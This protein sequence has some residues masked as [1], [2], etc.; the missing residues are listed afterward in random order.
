MAL[1]A[2]ALALSACQRVKDFAEVMRFYQC[3]IELPESMLVIND[4]LLKQEELPKDEI[5][6][7]IRYYG[8]DECNECALNH[9]VENYSLASLAERE[10]GAFRLMIIMAPADED[11]EIVIRQALD[12]SLPA[13]IYVD[14]SY[15][16]ESLGVIPGF[17]G[18]RTFLLNIK[19]TPVFV[20]DPTK[21]A[22]SLKRFRRALY[23]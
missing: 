12:M 11:R 4:G 15:H 22:S 19:G 7:L 16:F 5:H 1:V 17:R 2:T 10:N 18:T 3:S 14:D 21:S 13:R 23:K 20:G 6:V 8:P 9:M